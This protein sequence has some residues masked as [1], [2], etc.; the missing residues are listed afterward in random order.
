ML[1]D[2]ILINKT[3]DQAEQEGIAAIE[4]KSPNASEKAVMTALLSEHILVAGP[5]K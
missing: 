2:Q 4:I 5:L 3:C 1:A